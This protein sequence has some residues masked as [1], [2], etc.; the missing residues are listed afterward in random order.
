MTDSIKVPKPCRHVG[1]PKSCDWE[2][3]GSHP[4]CP[5][6]LCV[7]TGPSH[8]TGRSFSHIP[9]LGGHFRGCSCHTAQEYLTDS[10]PSHVVALQSFL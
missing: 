7:P 4:V 5:R 6:A 2:F 10:F 3:L 1:S 9:S 8:P